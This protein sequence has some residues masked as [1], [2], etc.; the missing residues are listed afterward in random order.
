LENTRFDAS[1]TEK[2]KSRKIVMGVKEDV[3]WV[4]EDILLFGNMQRIGIQ[5]V[6]MRLYGE[7]RWLAEW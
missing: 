2:E 1:D 6:S 4:E 7:S 3:K 5:E